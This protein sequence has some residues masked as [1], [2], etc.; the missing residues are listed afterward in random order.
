MPIHSILTINAGT[1]ATQLFFQPKTSPIH[2]LP[3]GYKLLAVLLLIVG[4]LLCP[5]AFGWLLLIPAILLLLVA[6]L[7]RIS[8]RDLLA[9]MLLLE[10]LVA[11]VAALAL[12]KPDGLAQFGWLMARSNI[13]LLAMILL[14]STTSPSALILF[15]RRCRVPTLLTT[16]LFLMCSYL[17]IIAEES[18]R[19]RRARDS[20]TFAPTRFWQWR[21]L[22]MLIGQL[23]IR[24]SERAERVYGAMASRGWQ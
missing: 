6:V 18:Q 9:R 3:A 1:M 14:A 16:T 5:P 8:F 24:A 4:N 17:V 19:M 21:S 23:F 12:L 15:L 22:S 7:A 13:S 20:R 11:G 2:R 10:P